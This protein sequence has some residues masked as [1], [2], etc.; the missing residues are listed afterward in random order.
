MHDNAHMADIR[1]I[2]FQARIVHM[3][4]AALRKWFGAVLDVLGGG[5]FPF[6]D[7]MNKPMILQPEVCRCRAVPPMKTSSQGEGKMPPVR[8]SLYGG[9]YYCLV[10]AIAPVTGPIPLF[11]PVSCM[12]E[13]NDAIPTDVKLEIAPEVL[14][15][16][17]ASAMMLMVNTQCLTSRE[18]LKADDI[19]GVHLKTETVVGTY[20]W[21]STAC[22]GARRIGPV[23][24]AIAQLPAI[25]NR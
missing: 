9:E 12:C 5:N 6:P 11:D 21:R 19:T 15:H 2:C 14:L 1:V 8:A 25:A 16:H 10:T 13:K 7:P 20:W 22:Q 4:L 17:E 24:A 23:S 3:K 18:N